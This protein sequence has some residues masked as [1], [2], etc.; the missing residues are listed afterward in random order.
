M[1]WRG[2][3]GGKRRLGLSC[4]RIPGPD[5]LGEAEK[6]RLTRPARGFASGG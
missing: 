6:G 1:A 4:Q 5:I 2:W 3:T